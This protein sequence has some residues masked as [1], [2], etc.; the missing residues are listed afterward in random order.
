MQPHVVIIAGVESPLAHSLSDAFGLLGFS[1]FSPQADFEL[2]ERRLSRL[3]EELDRAHAA[4][5]IFDHTLRQSDLASAEGFLRQEIEIVLQHH[6]RN[7]LL[8]VIPVGDVSV[9]KEMPD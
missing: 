4:I 2:G 7:P 3:D 5:L 8:A 6:S 1:T 9:T